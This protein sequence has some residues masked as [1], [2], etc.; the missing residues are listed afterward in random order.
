MNPNKLTLSE[1]G[2][3][4]FGSSE[5]GSSEPGSS[6]PGSSELGSS[7]S[8]LS[9]RV[10]VEFHWKNKRGGCGFMIEDCRRSNKEY[11]KCLNFFYDLK[12]NYP[13]IYNDVEIIEYQ[14]K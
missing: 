10:F 11:R 8:D 4:E 2:S 13:F 9:D 6:E 5:P 1:L 7:E 3:P 14:Q 12:D